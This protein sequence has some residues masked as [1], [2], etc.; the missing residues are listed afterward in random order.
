M[1]FAIRFIVSIILLIKANKKRPRIMI[2]RILQKL[3]NNWQSQ[4]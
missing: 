3:L 2:I 4:S 1:R